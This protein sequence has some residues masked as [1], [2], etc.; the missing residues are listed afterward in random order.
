MSTIIHEIRHEVCGRDTN[1]TQ[2]LL[3]ALCPCAVSA[4]ISCVAQ[5]KITVLM[6]CFYS[7]LNALIWPLY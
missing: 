7:L 3:L 5:A 6:N 4:Y 1:K 2:V